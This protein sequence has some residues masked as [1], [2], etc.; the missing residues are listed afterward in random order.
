MHSAYCGLCT[1]V[2]TNSLLTQYILHI[3][4]CYTLPCKSNANQNKIDNRKQYTHSVSLGICQIRCIFFSPHPTHL[5]WIYSVYKFN[6]WSKYESF[7]IVWRKICFIFVRSFKILSKFIQT[8]F[9]AFE[10]LNF[11]RYD[12]IAITLLVDVSFLSLLLERIHCKLEWKFVIF[13]LLVFW[14]FF[15]INL[16]ILILLNFWRP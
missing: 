9:C 14:N 6:S 2:P 4:T 13:F 16:I 8:I 11:I 5:I 12:T 7:S 3:T 15:D 10:Y 1:D